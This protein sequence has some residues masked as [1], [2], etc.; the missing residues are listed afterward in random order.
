MSYDNNEPDTIELVI[1]TLFEDEDM[2]SAIHARTLELSGINEVEWIA[3]NYLEGE[4][5]IDH[6]TENHNRT[7][8][9]RYWQY[10][11][12]AWTEAIAGALHKLTRRYTK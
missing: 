9:E 2:Q 1:N 12:D 10:N 3:L 8:Y 5:Q 7:R 11:N 6:T 4:G